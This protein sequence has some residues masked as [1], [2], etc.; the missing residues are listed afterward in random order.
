MREGQGRGGGAA[1]RTLDPRGATQ[2]QLLLSRGAAT[3]RSPG[4]CPDSMSVLSRSCQAHA[5]RCSNSWITRR[6]R[7]LPA[8]A[9]EFAEWKKVG[10]NIDYHV[11][12]DGHYY[13][14]PYAAGEKVTRGAL[15]RA[16]RGVLLQGPTGGQSPALPPQGS[17]HHRGRAYA[18]RPPP[19]RRVDPTTAH[20]LG[21]EDRTGHRRGDP[22]HPAS[23]GPTPNKASAPASASC[24]WARASARSAWRRP[25]GAHLPS[26]PVA[27]RA[28]SR[29]CARAW[30]AAPSHNSRVGAAHRPRQICGL[31]LLPLKPQTGDPPMLKHPTLDKL[32]T[33]AFV[34]YVP[35]AV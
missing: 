1:G 13:S 18:D 9:Y 17:P 11:E 20:P 33:A 19:I 26:A 23:A 32:Q 34:R 8:E 2:P 6:C 25:V 5:G 29:F 16:H 12:V 7:P 3:A 14:V 27:T 35:G 30:T 31:G 10:V 15:H 24:A 22:D 28:S 4:C 21:R